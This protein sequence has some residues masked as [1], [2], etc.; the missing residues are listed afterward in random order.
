MPVGTLGRLRPA[1]RE[2]PPSRRVQWDGPALPAAA[3]PPR[4]LVGS[5]VPESAC[6]GPG[7]GSP[8]Q[9]PRRAA[10]TGGEQ[11]HGAACRGLRGVS[12]PWGECKARAEVC[13]TL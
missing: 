6:A 9:P 1:T 12:G 7:P 13:R 2:A 4:R 8:R 5:V 3:R 10:G 11:G